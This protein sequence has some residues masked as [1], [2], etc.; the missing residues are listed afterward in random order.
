[1]ISYVPRTPVASRLRLPRDQRQRRTSLERTESVRRPGTCL[2]AR[3]YG[4]VS[5]SST[6]R[7]G[8]KRWNV[9]NTSLPQSNPDLARLGRLQAN[10]VA[11][12]PLEAGTPI[13]GHR[14]VERGPLRDPVGP[15]LEKPPGIR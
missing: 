6:E 11:T 12:T 1:M 5:T 7:T 4:F 3:G 2:I 15:V 13:V 10:L 14:H 9:F 8:N